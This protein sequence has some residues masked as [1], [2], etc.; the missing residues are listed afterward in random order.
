MVDVKRIRA[1]AR[2]VM[3]YNLDKRSVSRRPLIG[4]HDTIVRLLTEALSSKANSQHVFLYLCSITM[5]G[6]LELVVATILN[7]S[8]AP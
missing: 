3:P 7:H 8:I 1:G 2:V 4:H 6:G 5:Y